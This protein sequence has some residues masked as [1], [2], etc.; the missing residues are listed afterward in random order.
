MDVVTTI[1]L[2]TGGFMVF[3][4]FLVIL[5]IAGKAIFFEIYRRLVPRGCDVEIVNSNRQVSRYYR[6]PKE[7]QF[8][9]KGMTYVTNPEKVMSL[10]DEMKQ[11]VIKATFKRKERYERTKKRFE[12]KKRAAQLSLDKLEDTPANQAQIQQYNE[13]IENINQ[14]LKVL[15]KKQEEKEQLY[16][17]RR[18][19]KFYY[20]EGDP[21]P[22]D[23]FEMYTEMDS[24]AIDNIIARSMT[25][26]PK[27]VKDF[28]KQLKFLKFLTICAIIAA[29][30]AA[31]LCVSMKT[32]LQTIAQSMGVTLT[33]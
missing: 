5:I 12:D 7:G 23:F 21:V 30:A 18:R 6:V 13:Y 4:L 25:K 1:Y 15:A 28:E 32:D 29:A 20:I 3:A 33:M 10:S 27:A 11:E 9:I 31:I 19:G 22:K 8:K 17:N 2:I 14:R 26:D 24:I 16:Y